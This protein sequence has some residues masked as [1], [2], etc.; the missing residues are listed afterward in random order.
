MINV[1]P[2]KLDGLSVLRRLFG[3]YASCDQILDF[4]EQGLLAESVFWQ[5]L[6]DIAV[7][8]DTL[9]RGHVLRGHY[10]DRN[11]SPLGVLMELGDKLIT[12]HFWHHQIQENQVGPLLR[13]PL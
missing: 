5:H 12:V 8:C 4:R 10:N 6:L 11:G 13:N 9:L 3:L 1:T 2:S 7:Q